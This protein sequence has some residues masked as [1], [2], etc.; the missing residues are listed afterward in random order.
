[1]RRWT[2]ILYYPSW[3][4]V[5]WWC[6]PNPHG[7]SWVLSPRPPMSISLVLAAWEWHRHLCVTYTGFKVP[8]FGHV[9]RISHDLPSENSTHL[10]A[11]PPHFQNEQ[12]PQDLQNQ[13]LMTQNYF[14]LSI[15]DKARLGFSLP[16]CE[17]SDPCSHCVSLKVFLPPSPSFWSSKDPEAALGS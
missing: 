13:Y 14:P 3:D 1:M 4:Q 6:F 8:S 17:L 5:N 10:E 15:T 12:V 7:H 16:R 9:H 2:D 11:Y